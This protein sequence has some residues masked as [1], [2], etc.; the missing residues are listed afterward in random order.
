MLP[1]LE[2]SF[3]TEQGDVRWGATGIGPAVV[4]VH[5]TPWSSYTYYHLIDALSK[6]HRVYFYDLIGYG[7]SEMKTGQKVSLDIQSEIFSSLINFWELENPIVIAHDFGGAISLRAHLLHNIDYAKLILMNVVALAPW[8][9]P[10]F[11]HV[12]THQAAFSGVPS[13]IHSAVLEA[14]I[15]G[16]LHKKPEIDM[17]NSL[18]EPWLTERGQAAFYRQIAQA[19][20]VFTDEVEPLYSDI[21]C[22]VQILWGEN[23]D[24]IPIA[25]G[26]RL[27]QAIPHSEFFSISEA[28]HLVQLE[29]PKTVLEKIIKFLD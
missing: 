8:G 23:D 28:G 6:T 1:P 5:G 21:R 19:D 13:Y 26:R 10:F 27:H 11:A 3:S 2:H 22:P 9:S 24:W 25:T 15:K 14:Y 7:R 29:N 20:Q 16:A 12:R 4:L 18:L 17:M